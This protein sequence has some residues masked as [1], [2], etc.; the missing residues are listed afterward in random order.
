MNTKI[1]ID[2][3]TDEEVLALDE[4]QIARA[5]DAQ[6]VL[7]GVPLLPSR[8]VPPDKVEIENDVEAFEVCGILFFDQ[9]SAKAVSDV[10]ARVRASICTESYHGRWD[11]PRGLRGDSDKDVSVKEKRYMS[12]KQYSMHAAAIEKMSALRQQYENDMK[13]FETIKKQ[14][15]HIVE[16]VNDR[17]ERVRDEDR[18]K[19]RVRSEFAEYVSLVGDE[20]KAFACM[21]KASRARN[22]DRAIVGLP[23]LPI[24]VPA[25]VR[26]G[27]AQIPV[28][29]LRRLVKWI[30]E[31]KPLCLDGYL[32][33][34][35]GDP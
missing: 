32:Q 17:I 2:E 11:G 10:L 13:E 24:A 18:R 25:V 33:S 4:T 28:A 22:D 1:T 12:E 19:Q 6:C 16:S 35:N 26:L 31:G 23:M 8:P 30:D 34:E 29:G 27:L 15:Q 5:I 7:N 3:M 21:L 9:A 14:R 20:E